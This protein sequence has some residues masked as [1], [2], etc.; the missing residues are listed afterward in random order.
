MPEER[1]FKWKQCLIV[2][3]DI[4]MTCGKKCAQIA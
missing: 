3:A 4:K 2:R 1:E